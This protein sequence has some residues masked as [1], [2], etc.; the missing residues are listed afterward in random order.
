MSEPDPEMDEDFDA[1]T[2]EMRE[3]AEKIVD[4]LTGHALPVVMEALLN[5]IGLE[6]SAIACPDCRKQVAA[7]L[8]RR[9]P[10]TIERAEATAREHPQNTEHLH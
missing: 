7:E 3:L 8:M 1:E 9:L 4:I 2:A 10:F 5:A 6:L